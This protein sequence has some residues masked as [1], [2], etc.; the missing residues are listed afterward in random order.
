MLGCV[1]LVVD[2]RFGHL[3]SAGVPGSLLG[4]KAPVGS[5]QPRTPAGVKVPSAPINIAKNQQFSLTQPIFKGI[6]ASF[7]SHSF[8]YYSIVLSAFFFFL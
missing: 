6:A 2:F 7:L 4:A 5:P 1:K 3:L 8:R